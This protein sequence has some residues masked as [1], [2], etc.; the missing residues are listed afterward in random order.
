VP[1]SGNL[2]AGTGAVLISG[3]F[4]WRLCCE[5]YN[6]VLIFGNQDV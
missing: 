5:Q 6:T 3:Y 4:S 2:L 1:R